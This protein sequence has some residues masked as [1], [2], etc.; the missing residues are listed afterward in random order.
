MYTLSGPD[1]RCPEPTMEIMER[2]RPDLPVTEPLPGRA[3]L[4]SIRKAQEAFG[5][6][7]R[8]RLKD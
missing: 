3:P 4:M 5:Y 8:Y 7:P 2:F 1:T 6:A